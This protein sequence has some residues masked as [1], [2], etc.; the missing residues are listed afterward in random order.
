MIR[1][2]LLAFFLAVVAAFP[3]CAD[4]K[5]ELEALRERLQALQRDYQKTRESHADA[6]DSL[7]QS[8]RAISQT[9]RKLRQLESAQRE[10]RGELNDVKQE[11]GKVQ[12]DIRD[13]QQRLADLLRQSHLRGG[14]DAAR[15]L[16]SGQDPNHISRTL[17]Y[18]NYAS[19]AQIQLVDALRQDLGKLEL[20]RQAVSEKDRQL[21]QIRQIQL[22]EQQG[23]LKE[24]QARQVVL[25]KL[26]G[27][28]QSQRREIATLQ[29]DEK[30]L[31][32][33]VARLAKLA[34]RKARE[35]NGKRNRPAE[36]PNSPAKP[37]RPVGTVTEVPQAMFGDQPFS[38]LKGLLRLPV[39][40][41][42]MNRFGAP[43]EGGGV[44]WKGLFIRAQAGAEVRV[45]AAGRVVFAD[46]L[47]GF[48]NL[49]IVDHGQ[50]Y[51]S[52]Y[53][54]NESLYKQPGDEVKPGEA[55]AAT[56]NSGGQDESGVYF[57]LRHQGR[58][59]DPMAWV[60]RG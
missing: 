40:G 1:A 35:N 14:G 13:K 50:G 29:R 23:L 15:I 56:G 55:V 8:E 53:S 33:L 19:R 51:M 44:S 12:A 48:G 24:K 58:P 17:A 30:R 45:V 6:A 49:V 22:S 46:W 60:K 26:S 9:Q 32:D 31:S 20:L 21:G 36:Q 3:V 59:I 39:R 38:R 37:A 57:E 34:A 47:R 10:T 4:D 18:L 54:N 41:E 42:L 28:I 2:R 43:R 5:T 52:L 25:D 7:R 11:S 16:L 27:Q